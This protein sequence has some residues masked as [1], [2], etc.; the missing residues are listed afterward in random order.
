MALLDTIEKYKKNNVG[1]R[2]TFPELLEKLTKEDRKALL[3]AMAKGISTNTLV[4]ALRAEG[5]KIGD[6][7]FN[8]HR[9]G[10]CLCQENAK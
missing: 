3:D 10:T 1:A 4:Q 8:M 9:K 6:N 2:C 5:H 7:S